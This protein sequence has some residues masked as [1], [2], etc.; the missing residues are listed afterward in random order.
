MP[1]DGFTYER[2]I[3]MDA[4]LARLIADRST[5]TEDAWMLKAASFLFKWLWQTCGR[6][7][8]S[9]MVH[10]PDLCAPQVGTPCTFR[11][12][13]PAPLLSPPSPFPALTRRPDGW[14]QP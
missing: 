10:L 4:E 3:E 14:G 2:K 13:H 12:P 5:S 1:T 11:C 6:S 9:I 7:D 8:E